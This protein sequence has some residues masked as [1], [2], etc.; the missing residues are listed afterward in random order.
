MGE[1]S[2]TKNYAACA[3]CGHERGEHH[4]RAT[5]GQGW[6]RQACTCDAWVG[7]GD[8]GLRCQCTHTRAAHT[9]GGAECNARGFAGAASCPCPSYRASGAEQSAVPGKDPAMPAARELPILHCGACTH[10]EQHHHSDG[11]ANSC[12]WAGCSCTGMQVLSPHNADHSDWGPPAVHQSWD[13]CFH[14]GCGH[15]RAQH[16]LGGG[17]CLALGQTSQEESH[18]LE[19]G[20]P[21]AHL[22]EEPVPVVMDDC[23]RCEHR[24][25]AHGG[26]DQEC[27]EQLDGDDCPCTGYL[28]DSWPETAEVGVTADE[29]ELEAAAE[30]ERAAMPWVSLNPLPP[31]LVQYAVTG[32][33]VYEIAIPGDASVVAEDGMLKV[34]HPARTVLGITGVQSHPDLT[35][36]GVASAVEHEGDEG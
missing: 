33:Q 9:Y 6:C 17:N 1:T 27:G 25:E 31:V 7:P 22:R 18:C 23:L 2:G 13:R 8:S 4:A 21:P 35:Q 26:P 36:Q 29:W 32:G 11:R 5:A 15:E 10:P 20:E 14:A 28:P 3:V 30:R 34:Y 19:F 24:G 12:I 16:Y